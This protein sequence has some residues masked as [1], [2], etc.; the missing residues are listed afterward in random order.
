MKT[1]RRLP[2]TL[3]LG[4]LLIASTAAWSVHAADATIS[5]TGTIIPAANSAKATPDNKESTLATNKQKTA[6]TSLQQG[7][8]HAA[9]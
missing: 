1:N 7:K 9:R 4:T 6:D 5:F 8:D 3:I 2:Q